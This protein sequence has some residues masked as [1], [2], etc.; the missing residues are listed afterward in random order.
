MNSFP[1]FIATGVLLWSSLALGAGK[2][3]DLRVD[4]LSCPFCAYG[5]EKKLKKTEGVETVDIDLKRGVVVVKAREGVKLTE[6]QMKQLVKDAGF[7]LKSLTE[8]P[9]P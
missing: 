5:I 2:Q 8:K 3:Y 4:G 7:T 6:P 1:L 9:L